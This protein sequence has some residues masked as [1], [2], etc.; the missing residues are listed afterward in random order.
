MTSVPNNIYPDYCH[1]L[2]PTIGKWCPLLATDVQRLRTVGMFCDERALYH[3]DNHPVK[4]VRITG[5]VVAVDEFKGKKVFTVD[6]S[7][8]MCIECTAVAPPP[9]PATDAP[10]LPSHLNQIASLMAVQTTHDSKHAD[11]KNRVR[12]VDNEKEKE[13]TAASKGK[14]SGKVV[15]SVQS[16]AV[17]WDQVDVGTVVKIKGKVGSWWDAIQLEVIKIEVLRCTDQ[18]VRCWNE[19]MTFKRDVLSKSWVVSKEEEERCRM[20]REKEL[21]RA[22]KGK[23]GRADAEKE[24]KRK[25]AERREIVRREEDAK[26]RKAKEEEWLKAQAKVKKYPSMAVLK[27]AKGK[28]DALG[29]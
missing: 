13:K 23:G 16:P 1:S 19:V 3:F 2:S 24:K 11:N 15:P 18:E 4:W 26:R 21:R 28:Y 29:I 9:P 10:T 17:P 6:D 22:R 25:D 7:S 12:G 5:V 27:A 20:A 8:G 14:E